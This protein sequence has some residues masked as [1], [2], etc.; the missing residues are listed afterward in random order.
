MS[1]V[2]KN[3]SE[4]AA[5]AASL[6]RRVAECPPSGKAC[7]I[8]LS[9]ELGTGKT[10]FTQGVAEAL[11]ITETVSSPTF[12]IEKIYKIPHGPFE[13]LVH[14]DAYRLNNERELEVLGWEKIVT[15]PTNLIVIEWPERV[16]GLIPPEAFRV[17]LQHLEE[18]TRSVSLPYE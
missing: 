8:A 6:V 7:V 9:G 10:S 1:K 13:R 3:T 15:D 12:V 17:T 18:N 11:G 14:I 2:S 16:A 5:L 4:T